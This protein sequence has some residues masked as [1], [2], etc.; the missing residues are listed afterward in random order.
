LPYLL[1]IGCWGSFHSPQ[2]TDRT[3]TTPSFGRGTGRGDQNEIDENNYNLKIPRYV[4]TFKE[5]EIDLIAVREVLKQLKAE[6]VELKKKMD[7][8]LEELGYGS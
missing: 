1:E 8:Y 4:D 2:P 5:E 3:F 6:L 7:Q